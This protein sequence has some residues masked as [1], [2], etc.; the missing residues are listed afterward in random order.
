MAE[1]AQVSDVKL[2]AEE[3]EEEIP[4]HDGLLMLAR[5]DALYVEPAGKEFE[6]SM[7]N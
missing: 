5:S 2:E 3:M 6:Q 4:K 7:D 1:I